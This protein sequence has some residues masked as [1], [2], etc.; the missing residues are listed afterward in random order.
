MHLHSEQLTFKQAFDMLRILFPFFLFCHFSSNVEI[1]AE[2]L[3]TSDGFLFESNCTG[4]SRTVI[5]NS[6]WSAMLLFQKALKC[7]KSVSYLRVDHDMEY[8]TNCKTFKQSFQC[9]SKMKNK[10]CFTPDITVENMYF[11]PTYPGWRSYMM[12]INMCGNGSKQDVAEVGCL[13]MKS[14]Y[15]ARH[16][17]IMELDDCE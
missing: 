6:S 12:N 14:I 16:C 10:N 8:L 1:F 5:S 2:F 4:K 17:G 11:H 15:Y 13:Y 7:V 3:R 9:L